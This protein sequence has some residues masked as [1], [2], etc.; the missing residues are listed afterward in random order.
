MQHVGELATSSV[1][2]G[3]GGFGGNKGAAAVSFTLFRRRLILVS[4]HFAAHQVGG[5][6]P[7]GHTPGGGGMGGGPT[8]GDSAAHQ[9]GGLQ[10]VVHTRGGGYNP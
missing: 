1:G 9:V 2:C 10:P 5:L 3:V 7:V 6:Q 8:R 4:S